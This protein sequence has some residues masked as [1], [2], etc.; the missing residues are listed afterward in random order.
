[1][2]EEGKEFTVRLSSNRTTGYQWRPLGPLDERTV[3]LVKSQY[4]PFEG[5]AIGAGGEEVWTFLAVSPGDA[6]IR[7]EYVRPWEKSQSPVKTATIKVSVRSASQ[8]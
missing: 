5:G 1:M 3:R 8:K 4:V 6:E 2:A 7:M